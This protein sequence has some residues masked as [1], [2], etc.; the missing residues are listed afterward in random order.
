MFVHLPDCPDH[1]RDA[2]AAT[3][4][5]NL[6]LSNL[7]CANTANLGLMLADP[8]DLRQGRA[9]GRADGV[10]EAG[11]ISRYETD[12]VKALPQESGQP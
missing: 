11:A 6:P 7:G 12:K 1:S 8:G 3:D 5:L 9:L 4:P 2:D 10:R